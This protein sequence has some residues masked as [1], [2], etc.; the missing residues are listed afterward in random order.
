MTLL[1]QLLSNQYAFFADVSIDWKN[2]CG[3]LP[4]ITEAITADT[5]VSQ[6]QWSLDAGLSKGGVRVRVAEYSGLDVLQCAVP[7]GCMLTL[8]ALFAAADGGDQ[9]TIEWRLDHPPYCKWFFL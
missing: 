8:V 5:T 4:K 7:N 9:E 3:E 1:A 6:L 2:A